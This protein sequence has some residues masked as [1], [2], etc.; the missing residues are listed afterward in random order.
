MPAAEDDGSGDQPD[1]LELLVKGKPSSRGYR[2]AKT[3][4]GR[5]VRFTAD[6]QNRWHRAGV[7]RS[8]RHSAQGHDHILA[9]PAM[10]TCF[11][12]FIEARNPV[13]ARRR[14]QPRRRGLAVNVLASTRH[15]WYGPAM[16]E[17]R[18]ARSGPS[19]RPRSCSPRSIAPTRSAARFATSSRTRWRPTRATSRRA[20]AS[21][22]SSARST[23]RATKSTTKAQP[24]P[25]QA[26]GGRRAD[27]ADRRRTP[28]RRL[29]RPGRSRRRSSARRAARGRGRAITLLERH[30]LD[31]DYVDLEEPEHEAKLAPLR[32]E[33]KQHTV[34][35][36]YLRGQFIGGF[37]ALPR[38]SASAS[39]RSR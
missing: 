16:A 25:K 14:Q 13:R 22:S 33:T 1:R 4:R 23:S 7:C 15:P 3:G 26:R 8:Y 31:Y 35:Y 37:N 28:S 39:S 29:R 20:S 9:G 10:P 11:S 30:K 19:R 2:A 24:R 6:E 12:R 36:V 32:A 17:P 38:S 21:R 27:A 5:G 34:P 18:Q